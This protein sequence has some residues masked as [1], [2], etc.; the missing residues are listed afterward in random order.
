MN[1]AG[2][3]IMGKYPLPAM[4]IPKFVFWLI[5]PFLG[6][7]RKY[8]KL[9]VGIPFQF[10]NSYS[11]TNLEMTYRPFEETITDHFKQILDDGLI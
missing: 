6:Y 7:T 11:K 5:V 4:T 1:T 3:N 2:K 9:N 10:N 8:V